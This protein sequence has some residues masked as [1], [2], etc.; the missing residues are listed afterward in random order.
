M[1][2]VALWQVESSRT[3]DGTWVP[4]IGRQILNHRTTREVLNIFIYLCIWLCQVLVEVR[5]DL[6]L[7]LE[8]SVAVAHKL[9]C[10]E[11]RG[12]IH[13][14]THI[15]EKGMGTHSSILAWRILMD[16]GA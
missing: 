6:L 13:I 10:S 16:R 12:N 15:V 4:C 8:G 3:R 11:A 1:G 14:H 9:R 7:W 5:R 2:L